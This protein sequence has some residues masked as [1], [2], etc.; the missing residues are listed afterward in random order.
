[1][2]R[3]FLLIL[4][5][6]GIFF[7]MVACQKNEE[8]G[9]LEEYEKQ[10]INVTCEIVENSEPFCDKA[11]KAG[12]YTEYSKWEKAIDNTDVEVVLERADMYDEAFFEDKA[13][14]YLVDCSSGGGQYKYEGYETDDAVLYI[15]ISGSTEFLLNKLHAYHVFFVMDKEEAEKLDKAEL[16]IFSRD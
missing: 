14:I 3:Q 15:Q 16:S 4:C 6:I 9:R 10:E 2:K 12:I 5:I 7:T 1:M 13:L 8:T 11:V